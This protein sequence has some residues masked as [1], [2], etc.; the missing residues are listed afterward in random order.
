VGVKL[1]GYPEQPRVN[2][3]TGSRRRGQQVVE[4]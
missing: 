4:E 1:A 3:L 2:T